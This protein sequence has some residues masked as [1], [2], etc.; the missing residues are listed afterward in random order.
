MN[1]ENKDD[2]GKWAPWYVYVVLIIGVNLL[3]QRLIEDVP[4]IVN[5]MVTLA[6]VAAL[7]VGI[8]AVY[9]AMAR[10]GQRQR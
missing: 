5:V 1:A 8:T 2:D 6:L 10:G 3:K 7:I 9:R 4:V